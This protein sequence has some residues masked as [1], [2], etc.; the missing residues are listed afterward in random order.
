MIDQSE[1][2]DTGVKKFVDGIEI[3]AGKQLTGL[4]THNVLFRTNINGHLFTGGYAITLGATDLTGITNAG[5]GKIIM[6]KNILY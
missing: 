6:I 3:P 5:S 1:Q 4:S 2:Q